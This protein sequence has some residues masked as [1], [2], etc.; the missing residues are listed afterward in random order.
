MIKNIHIIHE[1]MENSYCINF[2]SIF[3][4][5][6][7]IEYGEFLHC[8]GKTFT[9]FNEIRKEIEEETDR[10]TGSNKEISHIPINLRIYSPNGMYCCKFYFIIYIF[11]YY[12]VTIY[13][14]VNHTLTHDN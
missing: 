8:R 9:D 7:F 10:V 3:M 2:I 1:L 14:V 6:I 12:L 11:E 13:K 4:Y 5:H